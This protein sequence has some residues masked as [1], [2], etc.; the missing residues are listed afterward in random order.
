M[1][2]GVVS[3]VQQ[4]DTLSKQ[5]PKKKESRSDGR[6]AF[7]STTCTLGEVLRLNKSRSRRMLGHWHS[8]LNAWQNKFKISQVSRKRR[9]LNFFQAFKN[10]TDV[11]LDSRQ[12]CFDQAFLLTNKNACKA[13]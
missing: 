13:I 8:Y 9:T 11:N 2:P 7:S 10:E 12:P 1:R 3:G 4:V 6:S 5:S